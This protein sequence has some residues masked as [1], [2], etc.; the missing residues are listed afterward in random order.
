MGIQ[1]Y[2]RDALVKVIQSVPD[3]GQVHNRYKYA[4]DWNVF[5]DK[6]T[7]TIAG[8]KQIRGWWI[9]IPTLPGGLNYDSF[10]THWHNFV[11]PIRAIMGYSDTDDSE[12][13]FE[14]MIYA[15]HGK[16]HEQGVLGLGPLQLAPTIDQVI[17]GGSID[18]ILPLIDIRTFGSVLC[19]Y[20]ELYLTVGV[21]DTSGFGVWQD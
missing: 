21:K 8:K 1:A 7:V 14:N 16:L 17:P 18:V 6:F 19:H 2:I 12:T 10:E 4:S 11:F 9:S 3:T 5:L 13:E 15:V 20:A